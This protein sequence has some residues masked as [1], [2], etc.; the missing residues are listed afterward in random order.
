MRFKTSQATEEFLE[1]A[2]ARVGARNK[3]VLGRAG[4]LL[5]LG[6][7][8]PSGFKASDSQGLELNDET[9][10]GDELREVVRAALNYRA[11]NTLDEV[12]YRHWFRTYFEFG[13]FRL[14]QIWEEVN[15]DQTAFVAALLRLCDLNQIG[16][17]IRAGEEPQAVVERPVL[18]QLTEGDEPWLLNAA[19]GNS[20]LIISGAPGR[21]KSQLALDLLM[22]VARQGVRFLFFDLKGELEENLPNPRQTENRQRFLHATGARYVRLISEGLPVNPLYRG[23]SEAENAQ[24]AAEIASLVHAFAPQLGAKQKRIIREAYQALREPDFR[25]LATELEQRG[26]EGVALAI[27]EKI[28]QFNLFTEAPRAVPMERWLAGR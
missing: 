20:L 27:I 13:C 4:L 12:G 21:G 6:Q 7:G 19:G 9:V 18:V 26:E 5:A 22:Q 15:G 11:G 28:A 14:K 24:I 10:V 2:F 17:G 1:A 16:E 23:R 8:L 3:A 25:S